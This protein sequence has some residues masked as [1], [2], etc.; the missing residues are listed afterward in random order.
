MSRKHCDMD[1]TSHSFY[2][3]HTHTAAHPKFLKT[4]SNIDELCPELIFE[5][6]SNGN[7]STET[8]T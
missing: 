3:P 2:Y 1:F 5:Q 7:V 6:D 4:K 8:S